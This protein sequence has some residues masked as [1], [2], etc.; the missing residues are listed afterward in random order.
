M[1]LYPLVPAAMPLNPALIRSAASELPV[2][3]SGQPGSTGTGMG[4]RGSASLGNLR[5]SRIRT[6]DL[7]LIWIGR[8]AIPGFR[9]GFFFC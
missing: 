6:I 2:R 1:L 3:T 5:A 4:E 7:L 9:Q 8:V